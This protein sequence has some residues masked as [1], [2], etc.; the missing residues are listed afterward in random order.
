MKREHID[1]A[2]ALLAAF[3]ALYYRIPKDK[4]EAF[5]A[6]YPRIA[7]LIGIIAAIVPFLPMVAANARKLI[8]P[9]NATDN[10]PAISTDNGADN[11]KEELDP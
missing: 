7:A 6:Q 3:V 11:G 2:L 1:V 5:E 4:R 8:S 9:G 10:Q